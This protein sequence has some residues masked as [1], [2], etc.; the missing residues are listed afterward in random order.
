M[1]ILDRY[2]QSL[3]TLDRLDP[4]AE[5]RLAH[6][7]RQGDPD[8]RRRLVEASLPFVIGVAREYRRWGVPLEDLIQQGNIGLLQAASRFDPD[9]SCRL[10]TYAVYW[11]RAEIRDYV[12]RQHRM[13]RV[14]TTRSERRAIRAWRSRGLDGADSLVEESGMP[15]E[16]AERL[17][18]MLKHG[19]VSID[20]P[21][22]G[23]APLV[24]RI[25]D[26]EP[27]PEEHLD[28]TLGRE[29]L[30]R[31]VADA[32]DTLSEREQRIVRARLMSEEPL[33]LEQLGTEMGVTKERVRQIEARLREKL[34]LELSELRAVA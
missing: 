15:A 2:R 9:R 32:I 34:R 18:A 1:D 14:G 13:A 3:S 17:L 26:D 23:R 7:A 30:R 28:A 21:Y 25:R 22:G 12:M 31:R 10:I 27:T 33:T 5:R 6:A 8:A 4:D 24:D 16:R 20:V 29:H 11:I 19:D